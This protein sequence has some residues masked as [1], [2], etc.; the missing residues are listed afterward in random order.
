MKT[1][2]I[3]LIAFL[4]PL[5]MAQQCNAI[6]ENFFIPKYNQV[7]A[8][9]SDSYKLNKSIVLFS[10]Q[11]LSAN[12]IKRVALLFNQDDKKL[13]FC[14]IAGQKLADYPNRYEIY[15]AFNSFSKVFQLHDYLEMIHQGNTPPP[16]PPPVT[17]SVTFPNYTY[18]SHLN[19]NGQKGCATVVTDQVF[20]TFA[21]QVNTR[22][23]ADQ[24]N[25]IKQNQKYYCL[26]MAQIMKIASLIQSQDDKLIALK[27]L[28]EKCYDLENYASAVVLFGSATHQSKWLEHCQKQLNNSVACTTS[29]ADFKDI[30]Q[31][32]KGKHFT[33]D[34][35]DHSRFFAKNKCLTSEQVVEVM[36]LFM[37][38]NDKME[39]AKMFYDK[40]S[41]KGNYYKC[42][43]ALT[44]TMQRDQLRD[45]LKTK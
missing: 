20:M 23:G 7:L 22:T 19:Y 42:V 38:D 4:S 1:L 34:M 26:S 33:N 15:D 29:D 28:Y 41:N 39:I 45:W 18:P 37:S 32:I 40:C 5:V 27:T 36:K 17:P 8:Q 31:S 3:L 43:D 44:F 11:C 13:E 9:S 30:L 24:M 2:L 12:Q 16:P 21:H 25:Y 10:G 6:S 14:K 35:L